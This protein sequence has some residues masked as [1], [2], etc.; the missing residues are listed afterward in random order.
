MPT[1]DLRYGEGSIPFN[2]DDDKF[3][4]LRPSAPA[5]P[6]TD[7]EI[8]ER[9]DSPIGSPPLEDIVSPGETVLFVVPDATRQTAAG[10]MINLLV[11]RLIANGTMPHEMAVIFATGIHRPVTEEEQREIVTPFIAQ[12]L[13]LF[14]HDARHP[15]KLFAVG[16]T[17]GGIPVELNWVL[18]EYDHIVLIGGVTFH[19]FAGFTGG[20]KL[21]CPG[22]ASAKTISA[23]HKLAFDCERHARRDG[24]GPGLLDGNAVHEA[25]VEAASKVK[26][27]FAVNTITDENGAATDMFCGD[28]IESHRAACDRF[29]AEHTVTIPEKRDVVVVSCGGSPYDL[30]LIQA[31]K[32]LDAAAA[33]CKDGGTIVLLAECREGLGREDFLDWFTSADSSHL[34]GRLCHDYQ[35]NGQTAWALL[36]KCERFDVRIVTELDEPATVLMRMKKATPEMLTGDEFDEQIGYIV[37][38]GSKVLIQA[39]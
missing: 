3:E 8:G 29:A 34:A 21:I 38:F 10:Q 11:R 12:R 5:W 28:W 15:V 22:L 35:V 1:I 27:S 14:H 6:L 26:I 24:V 37:P 9:F 33:A 23:T 25:F 39:E 13:K 31:H 18:T 20:R 36:E 30:N 7:V 17:S 16:E 2:F 4:V 19:Y 32:A